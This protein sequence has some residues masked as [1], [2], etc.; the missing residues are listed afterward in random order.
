MRIAV[1]GYCGCLKPVHHPP[2]C[3]GE[4]THTDRV[5]VVAVAVYAAEQAPPPPSRPIARVIET[6]T[7]TKGTDL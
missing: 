2:F 6:S 1:Q 7:P 3:T 5:R 4:C